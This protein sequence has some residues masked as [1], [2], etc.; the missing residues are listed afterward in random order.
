MVGLY[1]LVAFVVGW[2]V[3]HTLKVV[4]GLLEGN[5]IGDKVSLGAIIG[6]CTRSGGMPSG[7]TASFGAA[8]TYLGLLYGFDS[9]VFTLAV[10]VLVIIIYDAVNVRYAVGRQGEALN[11]IL[12]E[13]GEKTLP[14][15]EGHTIP[16]VVVGGAIGICMGLAVYWT[17]AR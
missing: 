6:Y 17:L 12:K 1:T 13:R 10:C 16:Q 4:I 11:R 2:L 14:V 9:G 7:H 8:T 5:K 3:A 15:V